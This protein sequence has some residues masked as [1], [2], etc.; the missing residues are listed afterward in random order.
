MKTEKDFELG[1]VR[2]RK[3]DIQ[4]YLEEMISMGMADEFEELAYERLIETG[5]I[6][7]S[8][9]MKITNRYKE[10]YNEKF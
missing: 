9:L 7:R 2:L 1:V 4:G 6:T 10:F 5:G 8:D 3:G